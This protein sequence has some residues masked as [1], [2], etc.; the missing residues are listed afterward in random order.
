MRAPALSAGVGRLLCKSRLANVGFTTH[1]TPPD[2]RDSSATTVA[3]PF[4]V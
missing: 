2:P 3:A 4:P 1:K